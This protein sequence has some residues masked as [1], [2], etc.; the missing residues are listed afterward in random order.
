MSGVYHGAPTSR[1]GCS[2]ALAQEMLSGMVIEQVRR[3]RVERGDLILNPLL[4]EEGTTCIE[5]PGKVIRCPLPQH[6]QKWLLLPWG[7]A[8]CR[9]S[10][11]ARSWVDSFSLNGIMLVR[12]VTTGTKAAAI[13]DCLSTLTECSL[14]QLGNNMNLALAKDLVTS[15][16][17]FNLIYF[18]NRVKK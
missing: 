10:G 17:H 4:P 6:K 15:A 7:A 16:M 18:I 12:L 14:S 8:L 3:S 11:E 13:W 5:A 1:A 9:P 2:L